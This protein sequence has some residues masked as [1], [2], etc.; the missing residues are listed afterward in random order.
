[1]PRGLNEVMYEAIAQGDKDFSAD[2]QDEAGQH[3]RNLFWRL[4]DRGRA[5]RWASARPGLNAQFIGADALV[6]QE[7]S[8]IGEERS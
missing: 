5:D 3:R 8:K 7:F 6:T 1:M 4:S 2:Q